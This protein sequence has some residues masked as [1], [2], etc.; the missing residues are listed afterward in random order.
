MEESNMDT[1]FFY[2]ETSEFLCRKHVKSK[3]RDDV[4][5]KT[6]I[7]KINFKLNKNSDKN[8]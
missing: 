3:G 8:K 7:E 4:N 1:M 2:F 5:E 6:T